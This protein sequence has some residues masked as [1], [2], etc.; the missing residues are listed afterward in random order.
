MYKIN[1]MLTVS[2]DSTTTAEEHSNTA[3]HVMNLGLMNELVK[4]TALHDKDFLCFLH[5]A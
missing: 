4:G 1:H 5:C 2:Y 3:F